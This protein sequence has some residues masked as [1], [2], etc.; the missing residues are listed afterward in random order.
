MSVARP[1]NWQ[2]PSGR[3]PW[4]VP[5]KIRDLINGH[6]KE[7]K[8]LHTR[9]SG[10]RNW[11]KHAKSYGLDLT[12]QPC[13]LVELTP[14]QLVEAGEELPVEQEW[15]VLVKKYGDDWWGAP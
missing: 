10:V 1:V 2:K 15:P 12:I 5:A 11:E 8:I 3:V 4:S 13:C 7:A 14:A 9:E 6:I